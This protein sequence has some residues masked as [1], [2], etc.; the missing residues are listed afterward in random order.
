MNILE[1]LEECSSLNDICRKIFG[2]HNYTNRE[3]VKKLLYENGV[4]WEEWLDKKKQEKEK[5]CLVC[6]KKLKQ[7]QKKF[8]SRSCSATYNNSLRKETL[9]CKNCGT[10]LKENQKEFCSNKCQTKYQYE[11]YIERWKNGEESG[12]SGVYN[13]SKHIRRYLFEKN[14]CKC[15]MCGWGE[16]NKFTGNIPL[17]VHHK[18]GDYTNN[19]EENLQLLCPNCHSLTETFKAHNKS[20]RKGRSKY[21]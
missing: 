14:D 1:I 16:T 3:K 4:D 10:P 17:E 6:G 11:Q 20:G 21:S 5:Y 8:C 15:E 12:L 9:Y 18:D 13:I 19:K 7:G 2:K